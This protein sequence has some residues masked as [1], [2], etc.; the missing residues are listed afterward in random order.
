MQINLY[1]FVCTVTIQALS[2]KVRTYPFIHAYSKYE[3]TRLYE[4][5]SGREAREE[6]ATSYAPTRNGIGSF[7]IPRVIRYHLIISDYS[8]SPFLRSPTIVSHREIERG[9]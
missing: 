4:V 3:H 7:V 9:K 6:E 2:W 8:A 1:I 5:N